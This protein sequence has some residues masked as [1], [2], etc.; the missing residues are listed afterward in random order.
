MVPWFDDLMDRVYGPF[1][2]I[3]AKLGVFFLRIFGYPVF[4]NEIHIELPNI[5]LVVAEECSGIRFLISILAIAVPLAYLTQKSWRRWGIIVVSTFFI[6][7]LVN[8]ARVAFAGIMG[9]GYGVELLHG[10]G[11]I[12]RGWFVAQIGVIVLF[13]ISWACGKAAHRQ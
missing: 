11:H 4:L 1:Q 6:T 9:N 8:G 7:M 5:N 3:S 12:F 10:P 13:I 2:L